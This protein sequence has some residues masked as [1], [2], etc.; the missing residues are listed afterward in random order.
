MSVKIPFYNTPAKQ[1]KAFVFGIE[2]FKRQEAKVEK[3][4][5]SIKKNV[6]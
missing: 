5:D 6:I 4:I 3:I 1:E 2:L